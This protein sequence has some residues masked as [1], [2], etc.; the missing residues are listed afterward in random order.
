MKNIVILGAGTGGAL[1]ANLLCHRLDLKEWTITVIDRSSLHVYQPGLLFLP[2][3]MYGY[4]SQEDVVRPITVPLPRN[5]GFVAADVQLIDHEQREVRTDKGVF[6]FQFLVS[7]LGCRVAPEEIE[8]MAEPMGT[9]V[10]TFYTLDG[11]LAMRADARS[12]WRRG[13]SSSTSA[14]CRSSVRSRRSSLRSLPTITT[15]KK[16]SAGPHRDFPGDALYRGLH[17]A[18]CKPRPC[19]KVADEK[20]VKVVPNFAT[21]AVDVPNKRHPHVRRPDGGIRSA[22]RD[23]AQSRPGRHRRLGARRR[24][25]LRGPLPD[26]RTR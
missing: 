26:T 9:D 19:S 18:E 17:Q 13:D 22:V 16:G 2:F 12:A 25:R 23:P 3:G 8:G 20:G 15:G 1:T 7:A 5:V 24:R 6:P 21:S 10:H 14:K 4:R 11:A